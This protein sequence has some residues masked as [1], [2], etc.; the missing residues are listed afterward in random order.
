M[1]AFGGF[2][3]FFVWRVVLAWYN[4]RRIFRPSILVPKSNPPYGY[5]RQIFS[6]RLILTYAF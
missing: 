3:S 1:T 5:V 6:G 2:F 4:V